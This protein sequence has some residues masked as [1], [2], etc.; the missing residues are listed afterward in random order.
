MAKLYE[1]S[2]CGVVTE[3][4]QHLCQPKEVG[5]KEEYCGVNP[6]RDICDQMNESV[7]FECRICGRAA[8]SKDLLCDPHRTKT[9]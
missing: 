6:V 8:E 1:C 5:S 9:K 7:S 3:D 2:N 4:K